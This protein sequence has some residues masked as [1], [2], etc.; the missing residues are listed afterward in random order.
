MEPLRPRDLYTGHGQR[1]FYE[2]CERHRQPYGTVSDKHG[3]LLQ[4]DLVTWYELSPSAL[5]D[6]ELAVLGRSVLR[7][8]RAVGLHGLIYWC[9][10][11]TRARPYL[12]ALL[13]GKVPFVYTTRLGRI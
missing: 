5:S 10:M 2:W 4:N 13:D 3:L 11:P 7:R 12:A 9:S 8:V 6:A 1:A